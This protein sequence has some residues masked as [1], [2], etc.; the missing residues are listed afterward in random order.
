[1]VSSI[2]VAKLAGVSQAT[3]SRVLNN[4]GKVNAETVEK[5]N[6]A[7]QQLNYRP[8]AAAR[9]LVSNRGSGTIAFICG[10]LTDPETAE[11]ASKA[12]MYMQNKG[13]VAELHIQDPDQ[14]EKVFEML[15]QTKAEGILLGPVLMGQAEMDGLKDAGI[16][17][18]FCGI[19]DLAT[20]NS[21]SMDNFTAGKIAAEHISLREHVL[22]G[23]LGGSEMD[24]RIQYR[25]KGFMEETKHR[26]TDVIAAMGEIADYDAVLSAMMARK[27]RPSAIV[28]ATDELGARAIDFL[29]AYGYSIPEDIQVAGIGNSRQSSMNYLQL[30]SVGLP[31]DV[32]IFKEGADRLLI[33]TAGEFKEKIGRISL[34]PELFQRR[35]T[36]EKK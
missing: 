1:M 6:A 10:P 31:E 24:Q 30:T 11:T 27:D 9:S 23:W 17:Y 8:N 34:Q 2:D 32:D 29:L 5:V 20:E 19:D 21:I 36:A 4:S 15:A 16:P 13:Y 3:V 22:I 26:G 28:A 12:I 35:S 25:Y 14:P 33:K 18:V 7:I